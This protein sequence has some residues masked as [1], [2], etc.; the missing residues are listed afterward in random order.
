MASTIGSASSWTLKIQRPQHDREKESESAG[1]VGHPPKPWP[2]L[3]DKV[4]ETFGLDA[5]RFLVSYDQIWNGSLSASP[6]GRKWPVLFTRM[7]STKGAEVYI[8]GDIYY[9]TLRTC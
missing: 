2:K 8:T 1:L 5:L 9:H 3:V 4:K 6:S 7:L